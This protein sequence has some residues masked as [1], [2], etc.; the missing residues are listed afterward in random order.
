M[1]NHHDNF[2]HSSAPATIGPGTPD[3]P[4]PAANSSNMLSRSYSRNSESSMGTRTDR[5]TNNM[6]STSHPEQPL[7]R[8]ELLNQTIACMSIRE[9]LS[10]SPAST[11]GRLRS[12]K[13][14]GTSE[15]R[16][17]PLRGHNLNGITS[18]SGPQDW[19]DSSPSVKGEEEDQSL[20]DKESDLDTDVE[21]ETE[22]SDDEASTTQEEKPKGDPQACLFVAS[23]AATRTDVQLVESVT[24]HFQKWGVLMNVK[25][26]KDWMQRPYSFVQFGNVEDAQRAMIEAQNTIVD[27]RHIRIEQAR[28]NRTLFILRFTRSTTEQELIDTLEQYGPVEDV[29]IFHDPRPTSKHKRYAFTK[30]A[31]RDD[32]IKAYVALRASSQWTVEWAPNL[33]NQ[34]QI[35]KESVF[36]GQLNPDMVTEAALHDRFKD[37]G[38]IKNIHLVKRNNKLGVGRTTAFAFIEYDSEQAARRA[39]DHENNTEF[40]DTTIRVQHR[41]TSEYRVQRQNAAMQAARNLADVPDMPRA[42]GAPIGSH[43]HGYG[44]GYQS[45][46]GPGVGRPIYYAPYYG[47]PGMPMAPHSYYGP[48]PSSQPVTMMNQPGGAP[49]GPHASSDGNQSY[50][51]GPGAYN[52]QA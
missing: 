45:Y 16:Y 31:Y 18:R 41:E 29:S 24:E 6:C 37:Y 9:E 20:P 26:L 27:G 10:P 30:F 52:Q 51:N 40:L 2:T 1:T 14:T 4:T 17:G 7:S 21:R 35:E 32:A 22:G 19:V 23:L 5:N 33:S 15:N 48:P 25:V 28:V 13:E 44:H 38:A 47:Y 42:P 49:R 8:E 12:K 11:D 50:Y 39:I 46:R 34:N 36:V 43:G 3:S